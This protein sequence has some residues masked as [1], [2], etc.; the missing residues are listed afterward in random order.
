MV[1]TILDILKL[2]LGWFYLCHGFV[3]LGFPAT[4]LDEE[5]WSCFMQT[6]PTLV[7]LMDD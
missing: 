1:F 5:V 2:G 7:Q 6:L 3:V 4:A